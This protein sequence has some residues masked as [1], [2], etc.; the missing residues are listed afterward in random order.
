MPINDI[1]NHLSDIHGVAGEIHDF[2][3]QSSIEKLSK[4]IDVTNLDP[5]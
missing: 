3:S 4:F 5:G 1:K 2:I